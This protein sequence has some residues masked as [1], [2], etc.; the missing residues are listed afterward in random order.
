MFERTVND[1]VTFKG[2]GLHS[3]NKASVRLVPAQ[4]GEGIYFVRTDSPSVKIA[5]HFSNVTSTKLATTLTSSGVSVA[6]VEHLLSALKGCGVNNVRVE[7]D[8]PELP[9]L[10]GSSKEFFEGIQHVGTQAQLRYRRLLRIA[11]R[12]D[13]RHEEKWARIE[14]SNQFEIHATIDWKHPVIGQQQWSFIQGV[15]SYEDIA[16]ARTFG[17]IEQVEALR[18]M[19]LAK[20]GSLENAVVLDAQKVLNPEGLRYPDEFVRHKVLDAI[21]DFALVPYDIQG[22]FWLHRSGHDLHSMI[23]MKILENPSNYEILES[24]EASEVTILETESEEVGME[25]ELALSKHLEAV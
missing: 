8:G 16:S 18:K 12:L 1:I 25:E 2:I 6:T 15:H 4:P 14:P 17:F 20:G 19:G 3:G 23:L 9:I 13:V 10:D 7:V 24:S 22:C 5:A 21:G 11:K